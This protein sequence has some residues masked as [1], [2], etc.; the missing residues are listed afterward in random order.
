LSIGFLLAPEL[1]Q[2]ASNPSVLGTQ[3]KGVRLMSTRHAGIV[4]ILSTLLILQ[5]TG[6]DDSGGNTSDVL[7]DSSGDTSLADST[8]LEDTDADT[9]D[10]DTTDADTTE[11]WQ[12]PAET[13]FPWA[14]EATPATCSDGVD[15]DH[16]GYPDCQDFGCA[17]NPAIFSCPQEAR[18][19][20]SP[21]ACQDGKDND[22]DALVDCAD[23]DC[24]KN[25]FHQIC[26]KPQ[27]EQDCTG[28]VD[29]DADG[30]AGCADLDCLIV[31]DTC[32]KS[33]LVRVLFDQTAD[34]TSAL[35]PNSDWVVDSWGRV[36]QPSN[37]TGPNQWSGALSSFGYDLYAS[38]DF[39]VESAI[40]WGPSLTYGDASNPQDLSNYAVLVLFEPSR[41]LSAAEKEAIIRFVQGGGGL[42]AVANHL[43]AD[44]DGNG[45]ASPQVFNDLFDDN[46][47]GADP[48]GLRFDEV[49][50][51]VTT[52]LTRLAKAEHAVLA[53]P[54]G[55]VGRIGFYQGC[56]AHF[57]GIDGVGLI[58]FDDS[59][60]ERSKLA[61]GAIELGA[62]RVVFVTDS[63]IGGDGTDSHGTVNTAHDSWDNTAQDNRALFLNAV[64]WLGAAR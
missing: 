53:G 50:L 3:T 16:N 7:P 13:P 37:P 45:F 62:G 48:F 9:T 31:E 14:G 46:P 15:N 49:D 22:Q 17:R 63:A 2:A 60:D 55:T 58:L 21:D 64:T 56:S 52:L 38:G 47:V 61:V 28:T 1:L 19:E 44:R 42:L 51:D 20:Y 34:E 30:F 10:A 27:Q 25:P 33:G 24:F 5:V 23:P 6:C 40:S 41:Q 12:P 54:F 32:D 39:L 57:T 35:G 26:D 4:W 11:V 43:G 36:P 59:P 8:E 29:T 18:S